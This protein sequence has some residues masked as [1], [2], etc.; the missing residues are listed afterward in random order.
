MCTA[1]APM[2]GYDKAAE[3]AKEALASGRTV[4]EIALE[5]EGVAARRSWTRFSIR[6]G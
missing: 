5:T 3:I 2:I 1:L 4:R 6:G